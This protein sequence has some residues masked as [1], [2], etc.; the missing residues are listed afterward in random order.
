MAK[1]V[2][3]GRVVAESSD[4]KNVEG[5]VYFP[6]ESVDWDA[7]EESSTTSR[8]FWKG[9]ASYYHVSDSKG[10]VVLDGAF[11]YQKPWP[12]ARSLVSER[13]AFWRDVVVDK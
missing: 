5:F 3:N 4:T 6:N 11:T 8:C 1:A 13:T 2:L 12:L 7:L 10:D 9:K